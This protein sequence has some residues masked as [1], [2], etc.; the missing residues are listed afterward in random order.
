MKKR[1][2][3]ITVLALFAILLCGCQ[4]KSKVNLSETEEKKDNDYIYL[5]DEKDVS[6]VS[7]F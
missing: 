4:N 5:Y 1:L 3:W 2:L 6:P 7:D